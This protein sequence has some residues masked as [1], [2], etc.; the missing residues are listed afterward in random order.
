MTKP[1]R[2]YWQL[3]RLM[4]DSRGLERAIRGK[5]KAS[6]LAMPFALVTPKK[7]RASKSAGPFLA[8]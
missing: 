1:R 6:H 4:A 2:L 3:W 7:Y 8:R 5:S